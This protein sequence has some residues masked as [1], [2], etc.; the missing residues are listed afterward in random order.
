ML[1]EEAFSKKCLLLDEAFEKMVFNYS[2]IWKSD[3][4]Q[5][6]QKNNV[7]CKACDVNGMV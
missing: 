2:I 1:I 7:A 4:E 6:K 5:I 3:L